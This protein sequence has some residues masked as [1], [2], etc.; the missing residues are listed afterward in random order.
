VE[1]VPTGIRIAAVEI[2]VAVGLDAIGHQVAINDGAGV[3]IQSEVEIVVAHDANPVHQRV[4]IQIERVARERDREDS[5]DLRGHTRGWADSVQ[6]TRAAQA[7]ELAR[8]GTHV[9]RQDRFTGLQVGDRLGR[10]DRSRIGRIEAEQMV[11]RRERER[12]R[13][14][15]PVFERFQWSKTARSDGAREH[16]TSR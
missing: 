4:E 16:E 12:R 5:A 8:R 7:I 15:L 10:S 1:D 14:K 11:A 3:R 6:P 2:Q 13:E 9:N